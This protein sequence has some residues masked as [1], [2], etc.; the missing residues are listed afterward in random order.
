MAAKKKFP[1]GPTNIMMDP[2]L[3]KRATEYSY[4]RGETLSEL[5]ERLLIEEIRHPTGQLF[6]EDN[7]PA[8]TA[9]LGILDRVKKA[10]SRGKTQPPKPSKKRPSAEG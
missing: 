10:P 3:K 4:G 6:D 9:E 5:I 2:R 1:K 7:P 8:G